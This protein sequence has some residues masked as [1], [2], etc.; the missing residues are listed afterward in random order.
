MNFHGATRL[1]QAGYLLPTSRVPTP[2]PR[3]WLTLHRTANVF[4]V[5][6]CLRSRQVFK[7]CRNL[8]NLISETG[9]VSA[10]RRYLTLLRAQCLV[11]HSLECAHLCTQR[12]KLVLY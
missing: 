6:L 7:S 10:L 3:R 2:I 4:M 8:S 9:H 12:T 1:L 11:G 5:P